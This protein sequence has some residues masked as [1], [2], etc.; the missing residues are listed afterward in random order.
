MAEDL[1][2]REKTILR[3]IV[4]YYV[5]AAIPIGSRWIAKYLDMGLSPATIRNV[6]ADLEFMGFLDHPYASA[7]RMPTD[8]GY[9]F[10]VDYLME[11]EA[12]QEQEQDTIRGALSSTE[13]QEELL[14]QSSKLLGKISQQLSI[15]TSPHL[16]SGT[17]EKLELVSISNS[18]LLVI[19]SIKGGLVK[20]ITL[21][22]QA[23]LK[24]NVLEELSSIMNERL[25]GLTLS[26]VR[27]SFA[28]RMRDVSDNKSGLVRLFIDSVDK[29]F[30]DSPELEK[31][32]IGGTSDVLKQ[33]EFEHPEDFRSIIEL[34]DNQQMIIHVLEKKDANQSG[35]TVS[36]GSENENNALK[37]YS[38]LTT[39]YS[40]GGVSGGVCVVGPR[41]MNYSKVVPLVDYIARTISSMLV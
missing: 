35:V 19:I 34:I 25:S 37:N 39:N 16:S 14:R 40:L 21:E 29:L 22:V 12:L 33:P 32:H 27:T 24:R 13:D 20:T 18:R 38:V 7:G 15:I 23:E 41:R 11:V 4:H 17:F 2:E 28:E 1:S 30:D 26:D 31:I 36:I 9:R 8:K 5:Q 10:Y 6:M 3:H